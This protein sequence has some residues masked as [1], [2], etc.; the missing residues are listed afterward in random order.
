M[1]A[2][3]VLAA[4]LLVHRRDTDLA[5]AAEAPRVSE[6]EIDGMAEAPKPTGW[7]KIEA[8]RIRASGRHGRK[9]RRCPTCRGRGSIPGIKAQRGKGMGS[10]FGPCP[11]CDGSGYIDD[12]EAR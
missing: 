11:D 9:G 6:W 7:D 4:A 1:R 5:D 8:D 2:S 12:E 10:N 3:A